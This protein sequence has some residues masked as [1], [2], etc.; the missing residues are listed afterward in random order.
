M[1]GFD[2]DHARVARLRAELEA[3]LAAFPPYAE[4]SAS[5]TWFDPEEV[6][7]NDRF[8]AIVRAH[9]KDRLRLPV[10]ALSLE[11]AA[12]HNFLFMHL[13]RLA[14]FVPSLLA[15]WLAAPPAFPMGRF[16]ARSIAR[17]LQDTEIVE[18]KEW[19][20]SPTEAAALASFFDAAIS[21]ALA[22]PAPP[23][24]ADP[25][26]VLPARAFETVQLAE[27]MHV[28]TKPLVEAWVRERTPL[29]DG[30]LADAF[31]R[32][33][34]L[35]ARLL[36]HGGFLDRLEAAFFAS[37]GERAKRLSLAVELVRYHADGTGD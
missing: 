35:A 8:D 37:E 27:I 22:T 5:P 29:A 16:T 10:V 28:P 17:I 20:W 18:G 13:R 3:V 4:K 2:G 21:A 15:A 14:W 12:Y 9:V 26:D 11:G 24:P 6:A 34:H 30:Q 1:I 19:A 31:D 7:M 33:A 23:P 36:L 32:D 25:F